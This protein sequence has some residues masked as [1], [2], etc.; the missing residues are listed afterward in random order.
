MEDSLDRLFQE[1]H[2]LGGAVL[3]AKNNTK[4]PARTPEKV[5][6]ESTAHCRESGRLTWVVL[7]WLI[8]HIEEIDEEVLLRETGKVGDLSVLG[9]LGEAAQQRRPYPK[10]ERIMASCMPHEKLEPFFYRVTRSPL[11]LRLTREKA[12]DIFRHW[13]Y[14]CSELRYLDSAA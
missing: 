3:L 10:F 2:Q 14:L 5:I 1:W 4:V 11:A 9:V 6:A 13:N 8:Q 7:D 12:L